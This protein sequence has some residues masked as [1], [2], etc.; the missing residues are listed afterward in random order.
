MSGDCLVPVE[1]TNFAVEKKLQ[2]LIKKNL[3]AVLYCRFVAS[4]FSTGVLHAGRIDSLALSEDN[5]PVIIIGETP[6]SA[7][8][9]TKF[10]RSGSVREPPVSNRSKFRNK[11]ALNGKQS[12]SKAHGVGLQIPLSLDSQIPQEDLVWAA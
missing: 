4:E 8:G 9:L 10:D 1:Q 3:A 11:E 12:K 5:N 7:G 6:G 2:S